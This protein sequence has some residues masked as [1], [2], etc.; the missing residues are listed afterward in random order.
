MSEVGESI[1]KGMEE[2]LAFAKGEE[3]GAVVH[4]PEEW[5]ARFGNVMAGIENM[6]I[7]SEGGVDWSRDAI[8]GERGLE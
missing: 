8:Y 6:N 5:K 1:I 4:P 3:T 2:A 7:G